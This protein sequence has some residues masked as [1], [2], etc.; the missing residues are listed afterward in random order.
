MPKPD[1]YALPL[2][3]YPVETETFTDPLFPGPNEEALR[4]D[5]LEA[6]KQLRA[7]LLVPEASRKPAQ[8]AEVTRLEAEVNRLDD[9]IQQ[10][11][12]VKVTLSLQCP[13]AAAL[14]RV[15]TRA[16]NL[17][18]QYGQPDSNLFPAADGR[19]YKFPEDLWRSI[20]GV[21]ELQPIR[22]EDQP[23]GFDRY[24]E[25]DLVP[26]LTRL[27]TAWEEITGWASTVMSRGPKRKPGNSD[28]ETP[29]T[30]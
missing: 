25:Q 9:Q 15:S 5:L 18:Q 8:V 3:V 23:E 1:L 19:A 2:P 6:A 13:D 27:P 14:S 16:T 29:Q 22:K 21:I 4:D 26:L 10:E 28:G 24:T 12:P 11:R 20:A 30:P 7:L 17:V